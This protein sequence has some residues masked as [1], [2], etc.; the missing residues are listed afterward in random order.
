MDRRYAVCSPGHTG[1]VPQ[2]WKRVFTRQARPL[3]ASDSGLYSDFMPSYGP[4][5]I[6]YNTFGSMGLQPRTAVA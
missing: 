6:E 2:L 5:S 1:L 4:S 3:C